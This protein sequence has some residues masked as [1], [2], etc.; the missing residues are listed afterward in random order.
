[1]DEVSVIQSRLDKGYDKYTVYNDICNNYSKYNYITK[2]E[3]EL[4]VSNIFETVFDTVIDTEYTTKYGVIERRHNIFRKKI[5][6][7]YNKCIL[8]G[9]PLVMCEAA[10]IVPFCDSE[11]KMK[12]SAHNGLMLEAGIHK[13]FDKYLWTISPQGNVVVS[14]KI[15]N[16]SRY[17]VINQY[18][19]KHIKLNIGTMKNMLHHYNKFVNLHLCES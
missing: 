18:N 17:K 5:S 12:Y 14:D 4:V 11:P 16:N 3:C 13:L 1:M 8:T 9:S 15:I 6:K 10:H 7:L 19:N 2:K